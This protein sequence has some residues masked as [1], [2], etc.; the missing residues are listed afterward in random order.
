MSYDAE[1]YLVGKRSRDD[2]FIPETKKPRNTFLDP[3]WGKEKII[4]HIT[5][6]SYLYINNA[7]DEV[8]NS[9]DFQGLLNFYDDLW[10]HC[11]SGEV[12]WFHVRTVYEKSP[13][14]NR[15]RLSPEYVF[16]SVRHSHIESIRWFVEVHNF[17]L[18]YVHDGKTMLHESVGRSPRIIEYL[19]SKGALQFDN[20]SSLFNT[21]I[22]FHCMTSFELC[23]RYACNA[24]DIRTIIECL[25]SKN[26]P[27][28]EAI[29]F[30]DVISE[31]RLFYNNVE[32]DNLFQLI[33]M[34]VFQPDTTQ[35]DGIGVIN[36]LHTFA[37]NNGNVNLENFLSNFEKCVCP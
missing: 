23:T 33:A 20:L 28:P 27:N 22:A 12:G 11:M 17:P 24:S 3:L 26:P 8:H 7:L 5:Q 34:Y 21:I 29:T 4:S 10:N 37:R 6:D 32:N 18:G 1:A 2:D 25:Q 19:L 35:S 31:T 16:T 9:L 13:V 14:K 36:Y 15:L 30:R